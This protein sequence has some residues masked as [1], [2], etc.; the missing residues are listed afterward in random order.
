MSSSLVVATTATTSV[1][2]R[3][4]RSSHD[5]CVK[6]TLCES[7]DVRARICDEQMYNKLCL[8]ICKDDLIDLLRKER[9]LGLAAYIGTLQSQSYLDVPNGCEVC[10]DHEN[11]FQ[12]KYDTHVHNMESIQSELVKIDNL[13]ESFN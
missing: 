4:E 1:A 10:V 6:S 11:H 7:E 2:V 12:V 3:L 5:F 13:L 8:S 9:E